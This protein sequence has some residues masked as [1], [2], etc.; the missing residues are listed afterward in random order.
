[1]QIV[2]NPQ[3]D[4]CKVETYLKTDI[5]SISLWDSQNSATALTLDTGSDG[6]FKVMIN[7][8]QNLFS[9]EEQKTVY[10]SEKGITVSLTGKFYLGSTE[11]LKSNQIEAAEKNLIDVINLPAGQYVIDAFSLLLNDN[12]GKP[13]YIQFAFCIFPINKYIKSAGVELHTVSNPISLK[14]AG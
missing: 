7:F 6:N 9:E 2:I 3:K 11:W 1:M 14:Y 8:S 5:A 10:K 12:L 4:V 13:K